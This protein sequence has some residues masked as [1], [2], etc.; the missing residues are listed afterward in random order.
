MS[1]SSRDYDVQEDLEPRD[2]KLIAE[3]VIREH[4]LKAWQEMDIVEVCDND[5]DCAHLTNQEFDLVVEYIEKASTP[6]VSVQL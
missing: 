3:S 4:M 2:L 1:F 5:I 6:S